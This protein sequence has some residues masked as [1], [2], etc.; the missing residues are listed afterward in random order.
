MVLLGGVCTSAPGAEECRELCPLHLASM[1]WEA[2]MGRRG[3]LLHSH[4]AVP[5]GRNRLLCLGCATTSLTASPGSLPL[6][7]PPP[8]PPGSVSALSKRSG[9]SAA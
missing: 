5:A 2:P 9:L 4:A 6:R 8:P 7:P 1:A 3:T